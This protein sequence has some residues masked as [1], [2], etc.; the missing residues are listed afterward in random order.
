MR[1]S[2]LASVLVLMASLGARAETAPSITIKAPWLRATP[3]SAPVAGGYAT[4][5]NTG[6]TPDRLVGATLPIAAEGQVHAMSMK[7]GLMHMERL[8][9][10][11]AIPAGATVVLMP[12]GNHLMFVKPTARL[13]EGDHLTGTLVFEKA[14][15][16]PVTFV[17]GGM[18]AKSA[19]GT[20]RRETKGHDM[21]GMDMPDMKGKP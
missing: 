2:S 17:V 13:K 20:A 8:D 3:N 21:Q 10:G 16:V 12:G 7:N 6:A 19:P 11:L 18:A 9:A 15:P 1:R 4:I 14:G 5:V